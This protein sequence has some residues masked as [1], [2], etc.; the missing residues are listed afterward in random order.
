MGVRHKWLHKTTKRK[1]M[2]KKK[3][4]ER[5]SKFLFDIHDC[6]FEGMSELV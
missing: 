6:T 5:Y 4:N 1:K 3:T 2:E